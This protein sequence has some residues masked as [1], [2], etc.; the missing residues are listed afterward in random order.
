M[1]FVVIVNGLPRTGKDTFS[2]FLQAQLLRMGIDSQNLST[3]DKIKDVAKQL[4]WDGEKDAQGRA[5]LS[6]LKM[7]AE[8]YYNGPTTELLKRMRDFNGVTILHVREPHNIAFFLGRFSGISVLVEREGSQ[9][10]DNRGD[11]SVYGYDYD[12]R[13]KNETYPQLQQEA[14]SVCRLVMSNI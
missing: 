14:E 10:F 2:V 5:F 1:N 3:V 7:L 12:Y 8:K 11:S 4:G 13:V 9:S 6:D